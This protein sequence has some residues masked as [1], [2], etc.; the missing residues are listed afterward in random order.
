MKD[1]KLTFRGDA[2]LRGVAREDD[3]AKGTFTLDQ[4]MKP[5]TI[6]AVKANGES[7][8][9]YYPKRPVGHL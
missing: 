2:L 5:A 1:V 8:N 4:D 9:A 3:E 6:D 7:F